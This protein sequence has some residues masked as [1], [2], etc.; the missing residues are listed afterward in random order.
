LGEKHGKDRVIFYR[1]DV[2]SHTN[3]DEAF[4]ACIEAFGQV[5]VLV[6]NAGV[7]SEHFWETVT[8]INFMVKPL[9]KCIKLG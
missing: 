3:F 6:N 9:K 4:E 1:L 2:T 7:A 5:D 8:Q